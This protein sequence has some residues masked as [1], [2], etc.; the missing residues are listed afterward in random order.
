MRLRRASG[1]RSEASRWRS[2]T[3]SRSFDRRCSLAGALRSNAWIR[4]GSS[5]PRS[6]RCPRGGVRAQRLHLVPGARLHEILDVPAALA[7]AILSI[8][9]GRGI[10]RRCTPR[11]AGRGLPGDGPRRRRALSSPTGSR[12]SCSSCGPPGHRRCEGAQHGLGYSRRECSP[13]ERSRSQASRSRPTLSLGTA[14]SSTGDYAAGARERPAAP[15]GL[16]FAAS[17]TGSP[18]VHPDLL[19]PRLEVRAPPMVA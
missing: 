12:R 19:G 3:C 5:L 14:R 15:S 4:Y 10:V 8:L 7:F 13:R 6:R 2:P 17:A 11:R 1:C 9:V 16:P 18:A